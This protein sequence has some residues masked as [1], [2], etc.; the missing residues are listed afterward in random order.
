[1]HA[2]TLVCRVPGSFRYFRHNQVPRGRGIM[3]RMTATADGCAP[4]PRGTD[5]RRRSVSEFAVQVF[6][7]IGAWTERGDQ[8]RSLAAMSDHILHDIGVSRPD[9]ETE[10]A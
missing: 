7:T 2:E 6:D 9:A 1:M 3:A 8:R 10:A 4:L 5:K